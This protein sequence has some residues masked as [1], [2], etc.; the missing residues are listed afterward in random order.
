ME[1][2]GLFTFHASYN[3]GSVMQAWTLQHTVEELGYEY[4]MIYFRIKAQKDEYSLLPLHGSLKLIARNILQISYIG[5]KRLSKRKYEALINKRLHVTDE[6]NTMDELEDHVWDY[7]TG[8]LGAAKSG[9]TLSRNSR[10]RRRIPGEY[11]ISALLTATE[12]YMKSK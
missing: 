4:D 7:D 9:R 10:H 1:K 3:F 5:H 11:I 12:L 2:V 8:R 6:M